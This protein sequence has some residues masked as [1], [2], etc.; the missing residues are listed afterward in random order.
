MNS[1]STKV[2]K[3]DLDFILDNFYKPALWGKK[4]T[5]FEYDGYVVTFEVTDIKLTDRT[6]G[7]MVELYKDGVYLE[8]WP[9]RYMPFDKEHRNLKV[10][11]RGIARAVYHVINWYEKRLIMMQHDYQN[12]ET[13]EEY[14]R[15]QVAEA[16]AEFLDSL[17]IDNEDVR[18]AYI[19]AQV[20]KVDERYTDG[21]LKEYEYTVLYSLYLAWFYF[22][23]AEHFASDIN[24]IEA[25]NKVDIEALHAEIYEKLDAI[26]RGEFIDTID[27]D[28]L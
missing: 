4:W 9:T 15:E 12:A 23:D 25:L 18:D 1:I 5:I 19:D 13:L 20:D 8:N 14:M 24:K 28:E 17:G 2:V 21:I 11:Y 16:A 22:A 26:E 7:Y 6:V 3:L 27:L 10:I